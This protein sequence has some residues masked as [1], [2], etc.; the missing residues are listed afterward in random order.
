MGTRQECSTVYQQQCSTRI[1]RQCQPTTRTVYEPY[2]ET[3]CSTEYKEDCEY[4]WQ[5][6]GHNKVWVPIPGT[7]R[8]NPYDSCREVSKTKERQVV[9]TQCRDQPQ[10]QCS[11]V[12]DSSAA[13]CQTRC[14]PTS[15][16]SSV[17]RCPGSTV[18]PATRRCQSGS[19]GGSPRRSATPPAPGQRWWRPGRAPRTRRLCSLRLEYRSNVLVVKLTLSNN[20]QF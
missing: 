10:Q 14:A 15:R 20:K 5:G 2:T 7:C 12:R 8:N 4:Q 19:A 16:W 1:E 11:Q 9:E 3:E 17:R 6:E 13:P 18:R